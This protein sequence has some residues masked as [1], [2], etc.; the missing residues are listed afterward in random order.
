MYSHIMM[1]IAIP[2]CYWLVKIV[3]VQP[4][5]MVACMH[6]YIP[7][8]QSSFARRRAEPPEH[9]GPQNC[10]SNK[11][12]DTHIGANI[13]IYIYI[14]IRTYVYMFIYIYI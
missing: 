13:Y 11:Q 14:Y 4:L 5:G 3:L 2:Y 8:A 6:L 10:N 7:N 1:A 9:Q 12:H